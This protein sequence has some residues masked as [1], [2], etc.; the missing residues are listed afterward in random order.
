MYSV[1]VAKAASTFL[2]AISLLATAGCGT[3]GHTTDKDCDHFLDQTLVCGSGYCRTP[4]CEKYA[5]PFQPH[6]WAWD[7]KAPAGWFVAPN[8]SAHGVVDWV[9]NKGDIKP[10]FTSNNAITCQY[11]AQGNPTSVPPK[12]GGVGG[13]CIA[14]ARQTSRSR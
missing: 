2:S 11:F 4:R 10:L 3:G 8:A 13:Y 5:S 9:E 6:T 7:W 12:D 14:V 1:K